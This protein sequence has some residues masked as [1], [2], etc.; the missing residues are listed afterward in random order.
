MAIESLIKEVESYGFDCEGGPLVNSRP[1]IDLKQRIA[2]LQGLATSQSWSGFLTSSVERFNREIIG[3]PIPEVPTELSGARR[4]FAID[5]LLEEVDE[6]KRAGSI[7]GQADA[8]LDIAYYA[9]G[10]IVEMGVSPTCIFEAVH[11]AN[12]RKVRGERGRQANSLGHDA[13]KP[14][15]WRRPDLEALLGFTLDDARRVQVEKLS[16]AVLDILLI[17]SADAED[18]SQKVV[19]DDYYKSTLQPLIPEEVRQTPRSPRIKL[20]VIG[21]G[22]HGK[23]T[24]CEMLRDSYGLKF[25]SSSMFCAECIMLPYFNSHDYLPSY[26]TAQ[27]CFDDRHGLTTI[28]DGDGNPIEC[29]HRAVWYDQIRAFNRD[30]DTALARAILV[31]NDVY[32]GMRSAEELRACLDV[33]LFDAVVWVDRSGHA[34]VE[35]ES[36]MTVTHEMADYVI[37]NNGSLEDLKVEVE[38]FMTIMGLELV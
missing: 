2:A 24:V 33:E 22:R 7:A 12:M 6:F 14:A 19:I 18:K 23:D 17:R 13:V 36:S 1:W 5:A 11:E 38:K 32:C 29:H 35:P 25:T 9:L 8:L 37:D 28:P 21:H 27:E 10:R 30:D 16:K 34:L 26:N 20:L 3:F 15:G 31:D 4:L